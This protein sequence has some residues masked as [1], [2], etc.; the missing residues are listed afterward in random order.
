[1]QDKNLVDN[2]T[3]NTKNSDN[4]NSNNNQNNNND[5]NN[6]NSNNK[7]LTIEEMK[8][9]IA[10]YYSSDR[11]VKNLFDRILA[12]DRQIELLK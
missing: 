3:N 8:E 1:M 11:I 6:N 5:N 4:N 2:N 10:P 12:V 7:E 9:L